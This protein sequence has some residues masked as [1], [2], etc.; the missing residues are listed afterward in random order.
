MVLLQYQVGME[1]RQLRY[2]V[3]LAE[4]QHFT[5]AAVR[6]NV[7]QPALSR[8]IRNLEAELGV[9]L[10]DRTSRRVALTDAGE[11]LVVR[12]RRI[13]DEIEAARRDA[14][15]LHELI[16]GRVSVGITTTPGSVP[17][18]GLL[19]AFNRL[20]P[21]VELDVREDLSVQLAQRLRSDELDAALLTAVGAEHRRQLELL[22]VA[23]E[24]LALCVARG[25]RLARRRRIA[26]ADL[27]D[28][29]FGVF[30]AGATIRALVEHAAARAG[31]EPR[32]AFE[33][34]DVARMRAIVCEGLAIAVLPRSQVLAGDD[35]CVAVALGDSSLVHHVFL[36][37]R[38]RR[39]PS[40][41]ARAFLA[42]AR[43]QLL[44]SQ[45]HS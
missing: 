12:A 38:R 37:W 28:E 15:N 35:D 29:P 44:A 32:I 19:A 17:V 31:F 8:Q 13:L 21:G 2:L 18:P 14:L 42:M 7:A 45:P 30:H 25:H 41:A 3:A 33:F 4:E 16:D 9:P 40:P 36:A 22:L 23:E 27:R 1:I 6:A 39:E 10:V 20:H 26:M 43:E 24:P 34:S 5:K 11:R